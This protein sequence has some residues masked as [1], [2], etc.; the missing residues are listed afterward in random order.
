MERGFEKIER[1]MTE[2]VCIDGTEYEKRTIIT[3]FYEDDFIDDEVIDI[4]YYKDWRLV[5]LDIE[6]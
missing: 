5:D 6:D 4:Y 3:T 2:K 1:S